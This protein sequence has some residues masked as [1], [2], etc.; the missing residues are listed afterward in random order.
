MNAALNPTMF[1]SPASSLFRHPTA[2]PFPSTKFSERYL[3]QHTDSNASANI[4]EE[5]NCAIW[6]RNLPP[7]VTYQE[8]LGSIQGGGRIWCSYINHPD[9]EKHHTAAAKVV[10]Y[11]AES[12]R[13]FLQ[14]VWTRTPEIRH[15]PIR[16]DLN[17]IRSAP[18]SLS[19]GT[20]RVLIVTG[21]DWFADKD[22]LIE[23]FGQQCQFQFDRAV[24]H[25]KLNGR[26]V[27]EFRFGSYR[28]QAE[29]CYKALTINRPRGFRKVEFGD[30]PC[31]VGETY[32][33]KAIALQRIQGI[34]VTDAY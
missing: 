30:D 13:A 26:A 32:L 1:A 24:L 15:Y 31:E 20:S 2:Q 19:E 7:D 12:A 8:L 34:G 4:P 25:I 22:Y 17:R 6:M 21:E 27:I 11:C 28:S 14:F 16:A 18:H 33:S 9:F 10:F 29:A 5:F 3:G 23:W